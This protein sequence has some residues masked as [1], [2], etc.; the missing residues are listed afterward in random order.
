MDEIMK[1]IE[2]TSLLFYADG[3]EFKADF[4]N[5]TSI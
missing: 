4:V 5:K 1:E 2:W 3:E